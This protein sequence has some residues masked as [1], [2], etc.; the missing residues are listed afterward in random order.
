MTKECIKKD[1]KLLWPWL[2]FLSKPPPGGMTLIFLS[3][4]VCNSAFLY[5]FAL[6]IKFICLCNIVNKRHKDRK[7]LAYILTF[8]RI[9]EFRRRY[10]RVIVNAHVTAWAFTR[11]Y[12]HKVIPNTIWKCERSWRVHALLLSTL[13]NI[14]TLII[15]YQRELNK[16]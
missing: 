16:K 11:K 10:V 6:I 13:K 3:W 4:M 15:T 2:F 9:G 14:R 12:V 7:A 8:R 5:K 1:N